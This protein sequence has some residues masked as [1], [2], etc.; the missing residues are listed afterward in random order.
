MSR[1]IHVYSRQQVVG[2]QADSQ[3]AVISISQPGDRLAW[4]PG[5]AG[6]LQLEF[7]DLAG[8]AAAYPDAVLFDEEMARQVREFADQHRER[9]F[10]VHCDAGISRSV[11]V[12]LWLRDYLEAQLFTHAIHTTQAANPLVLRLLNAPLWEET[13]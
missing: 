12:G 7:W 6:L 5:W 10:L 13:L 9:N 8:P 3:V 2:R 1:E 4:S 11:A